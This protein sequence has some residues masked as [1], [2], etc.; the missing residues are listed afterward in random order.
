M[1]RYLY[2]FLQTLWKSQFSSATP[3]L[4]TSL[5]VLLELLTLKKLA[6]QSKAELKNLFLDI[7]TAI[8]IKQGSI[9]EKLTQRHNG[10]QQADLDD[11]DNEI[12]ASIQF[13]QIQIKSIN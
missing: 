1:S 12:C 6:C 11:C 7:E 9:L 3:I 4:I 10:Q 2:Q 13:L 8:T 5:H